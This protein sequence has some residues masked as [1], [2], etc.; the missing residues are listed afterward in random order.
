MPNPLA[1]LTA[2]LK[3]DCVF[4]LRQ[5]RRHLGFSLSAVLALALGI[6]FSTTTFSFADALLYRPLDIPE[7]DRFVVLGGHDPNVERSFRSITPSDF[8]DFSESTQTLDGLS[9]SWFRVQNLTG[10]DEPVQ[11]VG[12]SVSSAF[13]ATARVAPR[14]GRVF[15]PEEFTRGK[16]RSVILAHLFWRKQFGED[17]NVIGRTIEIDGQAHSIVGVM[18]DGFRFPRAAEFW[19][20]LAFNS[21]EWASSGD[22]FLECFGRMKPGVSREQAEAEIKAIAERIAARHP[23]SHRGVTAR[24]E[25]LRERISGD[26]TAVYTRLTAGAVLFLLLIACANV[27]NLQLARVFGRVKEVA[28]RGAM[29]AGSFRI[30]RQI[31]VES[32]MLSGAGALLGLPLSA[33][34]LDL[35][36]ASMPPEIERFLPGWQRMGLNREVLVATALTALAA[37]IV[38]GLSPAWWLS[39]RSVSLGLADSSRGATSRGRQRLRSLLVISETALA[40]IL[41]AGASLMVKGFRNL[42]ELPLACNP[43]HILIWNIAL[44]SSRYESIE[45]RRNFY[46]SLLHEVATTPALS[47][48]ALLEDLPYSDGRSNRLFLIEGKPAPAGPQNVAQWQTASERAFSTLGITI[49][50]GRGIAASDAEGS[51]EI[52]VVSRQFVKRYFPGE[53]AIGRRLQI[54]GGPWV[55]I[56]GVVED[57]RHNSIE[58]QP[59]PVIYRPYQ[60]APPLAAWIAV[61]AGPDPTQF[62][63]AARAALRRVDP[64][65]PK[66]QLQTYRRLIR[67]HVVGFGYLASMLATLGC[68]A[69][70]LS[71]L[72]VYS[73]MAYTVGERTREI[74]IRMA[75][76]ATAKEVLRMVLRRGSALAGI[77]LAIGLAGAFAVASLLAQVLFGVS[78][79]DPLVFI[80]VP[81]A[82]ALSLALACLLPARRAASTNPIVALREE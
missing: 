24:V 58:R 72:G 53:S 13:F 31:L 62:S 70:F 63:S 59:R 39:R 54:D 22:F 43:D 64:A 73:L 44:P 51:Q 52:A 3:D 65:Q 7:L 8:V 41:L 36:K 61:A 49:L 33:W 60:Q 4:G 42:S 47:S 18:P 74:G 55:T 37:G 69:L 35:M 50:E 68:V 32:V 71:V 45:L 82:L 76:G 77:G 57:T 23:E 56:V 17:P 16:N 25:L 14:L 38:A 10:A 27:A 46:R 67:S 2:G 29:G 19:T 6:S 15:L 48:A 11:A 80:A 34:L 12:H 5:F 79:T 26:L 81:A 21:R 1:W 9:A 66:A 75:L 20:P 28:I 30:L 78:A 40:V